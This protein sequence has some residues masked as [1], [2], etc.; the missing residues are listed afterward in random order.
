MGGGHRAIVA[1]VHGLQHVDGF[2]SAALADQDSVGAHSQRI[3]NQ[4]ANGDFAATFHVGWARLER[5]DVLLLELQL[6]GILDGYNAL[7]LANGLR[8][9]V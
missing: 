7:A 2:A 4:V 3:A 6:G 9:Y 1:G 8:E 5:D